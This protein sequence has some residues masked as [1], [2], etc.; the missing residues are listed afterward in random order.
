[1]KVAVVSNR[2]TEGV[3]NRF[4]TPCPERCGK[5]TIQGVI[6]GLCESGH[7]VMFAEADSTLTENLIQ[8]MPPHTET[9]EPSGIVFNLAYGIQ[10]NARYTHLPAM[11]EMTGVPY[12][13]SDPFGHALA[14]DK[15]TTK[16]IL[17]NAGIPTPE[18]K[19]FH[20]PGEDVGGLRFPLIVKPR[21]ESTSF[22]LRLVYNRSQLTDAVDNIITTYQQGALVE[23]Y[24]EG[25][26]FCAGVIG[27]RNPEVLPI[28]E[29]DF[30]HR[31]QKF[32][33]YEDKYHKSEDEPVKRQDTI[34]R[35]WSIESS[36]RRTNDTSVWRRLNAMTPVNIDTICSRS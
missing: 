22:G 31:R 1:M 16:I 9:S 34:L 26:E 36:T 23:E 27:N 33:T 17:Q 8:F 11:L 19:V 30:K 21:N 3:I 25:L 2:K 18:F 15:V 5:K 12:T 24:I 20:H 10:G 4:G 14:L 7:T 28:V 6:D 13:G 32:L 29:V 35:A